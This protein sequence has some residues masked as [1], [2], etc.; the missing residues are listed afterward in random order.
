[1][2]KKLYVQPEITVKECELENALL[3]GTKIEDNGDDDANE[4]DAKPSIWNYLDE[5]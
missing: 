2:E 4:L 5:E 1:M 3:T